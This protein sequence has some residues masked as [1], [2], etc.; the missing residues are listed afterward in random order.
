MLFKKLLGYPAPQDSLQFLFIHI[1]PVQ[2]ILTDKVHAFEK[3]L[4]FFSYVFFL[5]FG[6]LLDYQLSSLTL[7]SIPDSNF[8]T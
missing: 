2:K 6:F 4:Q 7:P 1:F 8:K 5:S 3:L